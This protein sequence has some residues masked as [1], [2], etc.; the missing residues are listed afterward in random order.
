M[1]EVTVSSKGQIV[2]PKDIR[3]TFG[4]KEGDR[5]RIEVEGDHLSIRR[6]QMTVPPD[7]RRWRGYLAGTKAVEDHLVPP[8]RGNPR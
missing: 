1:P 8:G 6:T 3:K 5:V 7:W 2:L 4:L